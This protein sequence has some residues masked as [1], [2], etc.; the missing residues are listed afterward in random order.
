M[1]LDVLQRKIT[2]R[3]ARLL[4]YSR[5]VRRNLPAHFATVR[6]AAGAVEDAMQ[7][8]EQRFLNVSQTLE[9]TNNL[10]RDVV[11]HCEALISLALGQGGGEI[12]IDTAAEHIWA[13][14][15]FVEREDRRMAD[16]IGQ[17]TESYQQIEL[18]LEMEQ[19]L[20]RTIAPLNY[21]QTLFRVESAGLP[22]E[23]QDMFS[24]LVRDMER[25]RQRVEGGFREKF[26]LIRQIQS[27]LA[28]AVTHLTAEEARVRETITGLREHMTQSLA[29]MKNSYE[30]NRD[31]DT[32]LIDVSRAVS[33]ATGQIVMA[34]QSQDIISQKF[35]HIRAVLAEMEAS[36]ADLPPARAATCRSLRFIEQSGQVATAQLGAMKEELTKAGQ[37][38]GGGLR[39][40][41]RH[42]ESLDGDCLA[43]RDLDTVTTG[44]DGAVQIL[45]DSLG[46]VRRLVRTAGSH[47]TEA[48]RTIEPIGGMTTNFTSFMRELSLE[49][50]LIGLNAEVQATHVGHGTGLEVLSANTSAISRET[51]R[52]SE[53]LAQQ[54]DTLTAGLGRVVEVF[55]EIRDENQ[56][57][58][59]TLDVDISADEHSLH[60][61]RDSALKVLLHLA[62][63]LPKLTAHTQ[64]AKEESDFSAAT[65]GQVAALEGAL[66]GLIVAAGEAA[67][68]TGVEV[69]TQGLTDRFISS[70]TMR[71]QIETHHD[72]VGAAPGPAAATTV[73]TGEIDLF[74]DDPPA[75]AP[76]PGS[77]PGDLTLFAENSPVPETNPATGTEADLWLEQVGPAGP[78]DQH[79]PASSGGMAPAV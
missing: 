3:W 28:T 8:V 52:L 49:I 38:I 76:V 40:I 23:V 17:L 18:T 56:K 69:K 72:A 37:A 63:Q 36:Y 20:G 57:F 30:K 75:A 5:R 70:Y 61:Y 4:P 46:N 22:V 33:S 53:Q 34:L 51:S 7:D 77:P 47:A 64:S 44:V 54:L 60:D 62:E 42:M 43:L 67:E 74:V 35:Q 1:S 21:V 71:S 65:T 68:S 26:E 10:S 55:R 12:M 48:H 59:L 29:A 39:Q 24:A 16:L 9:A 19:T 78:V 45:L 11:E 27:I 15:E 2:A 13:A 58:S 32:R 25:I 41:I 50:Q 73:A 14:I 66:A 6:A 31:R 79:K